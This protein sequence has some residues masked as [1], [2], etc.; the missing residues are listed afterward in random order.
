MIS[1]KRTSAIIRGALAAH[2]PYKR[3]CKRARV[4]Y[5]AIVP[6]H[7]VTVR[8]RAVDTSGVAS[9]TDRVVL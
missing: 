8:R 7:V 3:K 6:G 5:G 1:G 4:K 2:T 9:G